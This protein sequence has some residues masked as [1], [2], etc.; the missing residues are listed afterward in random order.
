M[1][2]IKD[3]DQLEFENFK[4]PFGGKLRSDN[5]WVRLASMIPWDD[6]E[7]K[8][9]SQFSKDMG[10]PAKPFRMALGSLIIKERLS[11]TDEETVEQLSEN[12][13]MQYFIGLEQYMDEEPF[14]PSMM[15]H[16][17][18]RL[19][20]D[21]VMEINSRIV[22]DAMKDDSNNDED[23]TPSGTSST[24]EGKNNPGNHEDKNSGILMM[25][26][27][28]T[29]ADITYPTDLSLLNEAREKLEKSIDVLY[30]PCRETI[31]KPRTY[32]KNARRDYLRIAKRRKKPYKALRTAIRKQLQYIRRDL[33]HINVLL[34]NGSSLEH[35]TRWQYRDFLVISE[36]FRQQE[37][38]YNENS[39]SI[40]D[41]I[42][43]ISQPHVRPIVRGKA[44]A[45][46]E[47]G[48]KIALSLVDGYHILEKI[49]FDSFNE[50][51]LLKEQVE[52][53]RDRT[54]HYP[55]AVLA[56]K[57]YRN[58]DNIEYCKDKNIRLSGPR[59]GRPPKDVSKDKQQERLD[60]GMR[61]AIEGA[62]GVAKR[63]YGLNRI[64]GKLS[65][66]SETTIALIFL[67]MNLE[68]RLRDFLVS[69][70]NRYFMFLKY[71]FCVNF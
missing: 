43:S 62:Y 47:F 52:R 67:V 8:Y 7:E 6:L 65:T 35:L 54:G 70:F 20:R 14:D 57:L 1:Y 23:D 9:S 28:V 40:D 41:R 66:T 21:V 56:D 26:A 18:K 49:S 17:R 25:D 16:F 12:H 38:M 2:R 33:M 53:Y 10:A 71:D 11:I 63:K 61:N 34:L 60:T 27:S 39:H 30:E 42:V 58:R 3:R 69:F 15:V 64:M 48:A 36:F 46:V 45:D 50:A 51:G 5:R 24:D 4:T 32:R 13:Y 59:L 22:E 68:K 31:V 37:A 44:S 19:G 29:P 55:E